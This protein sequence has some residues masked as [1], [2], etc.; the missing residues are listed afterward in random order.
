[1]FRLVDRSRRHDSHLRLAYLSGMGKPVSG[2]RSV[3]E[4]TRRIGFNDE[5]H[6]THEE[7]RGAQLSCLSC[8]SWFIFFPARPIRFD[9]KRP[10]QSMRVRVRAMV[11][12]SPLQ[13][14][15]QIV[16]SKT[17]FLTEPQRHRVALKRERNLDR[18]WWGS[19]A[20]RFWTRTA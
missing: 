13:T 15:E 2:S 18:K 1:M 6:Q 16:R 7:G 3:A 14:D 19:S 9:R 5:I 10:V 12:R 17:W 20:S 11:A 4:P 8:I